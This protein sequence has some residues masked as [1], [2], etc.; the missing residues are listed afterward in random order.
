MPAGVEL[1]QPGWLLALPAMA[2]LLVLARLDWWRAAA[3]ERPVRR[4]ETRRLAIRLAWTML[5]VLALGGITIVRPL[6]RQATL[7]VLDE[8]A[9]TAGVHDQIAA[10]ARA[11]ES[12]LPAGDRLGVIAVADQARVEEAPTDRPVF[13][14]PGATLADQATDL[15]AGLRLAGAILPQ[16]FTRRAV[17]ISDGRQTR[18]D[19]VAAARELANR[20]TSVDVLPIGEAAA[21]DIRLDSVDLPRTAYEGEIPTLTA[22]VFSDKPAGATLRVWRDDG[23]LVEQRH[24]QLSGGAQ[25]TA[26]PLDP[27]RDPGLHRYRVDVVADDAATDSTPVNNVLGAVQTVA[28]PPRVLVVAT[29]GPPTDSLMGALRASGADVRQVEPSAAPTELTGW[30]NYQAVVLADVAAEM[31]PPAS[32]DQLEAYVRELGR[33][34]VMTGGPSAFGAGGY[35]G[36]GIERAM[37]VYMD[38][39]GRGRQPRVALALVI[40]KS[41]SMAGTK[42][43]MAKEAAIRSLKVLGPL[44]QATV[45]AFDAVPQ[46]VAAPTAL[47][48]EGRQQLE[49]AIGGVY[50]GGGT[51][52]YPAVAAAFDTLSTVDADGKHLILLTDGV[53]GS[54][55]NY[56]PL[57]DQMRES[58][59]TMSTVAVGEDAD[60]GL[61]QVLARAGRGRYHF[62]ANPADIP[63]IFTRETLMA[64]RALLVDTRFF[65]SVAS[66]TALL[67]GLTSTPPLDGYIAATPKERAEVVLV[68][69]DGDPLL[70]A[71]Q[72]GAG[73]SVAWTSD[74]GGRWSAAWAG[75]PAATL[76]WGNVLSWL[77]PAQTSG[78]LTVRV[79][80]AGTGTATVTA[81]VAASDGAWGAVHPTQAHVIAPD[82]SSQ[83]V[84][85]T[86]AGPGVYRGAIGAQQ[87]GAYVVTVSQDTGGAPGKSADTAVAGGVANAAAD[88]ANAANAANAAADAAGAANAAN[89]AR[90]A[91]GAAG[92]ARGVTLRGETGW[93]APYPAEFR[94]TGADRAFLA[95]IAAAGG[96]RVLDDPVQAVRPA[97]HA[98]PSRWPLWPVLVVLAA[99]L[100]PLE[101]ATRRF[102]PPAIRLPA[103]PAPSS[104]A[105]S[106]DSASE[107]APA[108]TTDRLLEAKRARR[109]L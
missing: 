93:V 15:A 63:E 27:V 82:G 67:R 88:A 74:V 80:A 102:L 48:D 51:E 98:T 32:L 19:A 45:L 106:P 11:S 26:V 100:W 49:H 6:D 54:T 50:A 43:E 29:P 33:G 28:G 101:I 94:Q 25:E 87:S 24:V 104:V 40:D 61:L 91:A 73:R 2:A 99:V 36:T 58:H 75:Q 71:W 21:A 20:G 39:R 52:I 37:P 66:D 92:A 31:L 10:A 34:L 13:V 42:M 59:V 105:S 8:S 41:G 96:G 7:L 69:P 103:R 57:L 18:G 5:V 53:S 17:L 78:P 35:S 81:E 1:D 9:S 70:A 3:R 56:Q 62:T 46:W 22:R 65:P 47:S 16:D 55:G 68:T 95:Q 83:D 108:S 76:L 77:L 4:Q 12:A 107:D 60:T 97:E 38:V 72:Y 79:E 86:P 109:R 84:D 14:R 30:A 90:D 23:E 89:A 64:T 44:D 85:L